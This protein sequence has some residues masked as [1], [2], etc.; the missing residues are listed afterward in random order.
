MLE[1]LLDS[2]FGQEPEI[3]KITSA[4]SEVDN[5][6]QLWRVRNEKGTPPRAAVNA[7]DC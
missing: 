4:Q 7:A 2:L 5:F 6:R 3:V 1:E